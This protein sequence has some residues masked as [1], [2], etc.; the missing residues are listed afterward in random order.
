MNRY[1]TRVNPIL[2]NRL[3]FALEE[4]EN[5]IEIE[6]EFLGTHLQQIRQ[7]F[8]NHWDTLEK[9]NPEDRLVKVVLGQFETI[10]ALFAVEARLNRQE[11]IEL[12]N[13]R[14]LPIPK[15]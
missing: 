14:I 11:I 2:Y 6:A 5:S 12:R 3:S 15:P 4:I 1:T 13:I 10:P 8:S 7:Q 9:P